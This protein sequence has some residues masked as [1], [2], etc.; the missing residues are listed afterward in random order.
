MLGHLGIVRN[1][2]DFAPLAVLDHISASG[3][4]FTDRLSRIDLTVL[5]G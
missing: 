1:D 4:G 2:P 3:P 5:G